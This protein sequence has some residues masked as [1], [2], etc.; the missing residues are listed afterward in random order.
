MLHFVIFHIIL[1]IV[2]QNSQDSSLSTFVANSMSVPYSSTSSSCASLSMFPLY[3]GDCVP[4]NEQQ[5]LLDDASSISSALPFQFQKGLLYFGLCFPSEKQFDFSAEHDVLPSLNRENLDARNDI[6]STALKL[7]T[8]TTKSLDCSVVSVP[9][10]YSLGKEVLPPP[11]FES[12]TSLVTSTVTL[13]STY[14]VPQLHSVAATPVS[15]AAPRSSGFSPQSPVALLL[16]T[17]A[18]SPNT[19]TWLTRANQETGTGSLLLTTANQET[20]TGSSLLNTA[21]QE[22]GT[23]LSLLTTANQELGNRSTKT[24]HKPAKSELYKTELCRAFSEKGSCGYGEKCQFAHGECDR[25]NILRH[26]KYKTKQCWTY[27]STGFCYYGAR[28]NFIHDENRLDRNQGQ[29][30]DPKF[31]TKLDP[32]SGINRDPSF[33]TNLNPASGINLVPSSNSSMNF[34]PRRAVQWDTRLNVNSDPNLEVNSDLAELSWNHRAK[35]ALNTGGVGLNFDSRIALSLK[36]GISLNSQPKAGQNAK[37]NTWNISNGTVP[38]SNGMVPVSSGMV[39]VS[40]GM[41]RSSP[42]ITTLDIGARAAL[43]SGQNLRQR[44]QFNT[45]GWNIE[46][47]NFGHSSAFTDANHAELSGSVARD[48]NIAFKYSRSEFS[49]NA[50]DDKLAHGRSHLLVLSP[51]QFPPIQTKISSTNV[52]RP[53]GHYLNKHKGLLGTSLNQSCTESCS[54]SH[55]SKESTSNIWSSL[56]K[57]PRGWTLS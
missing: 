12:L 47:Q 30:S 33:G 57:H 21:N 15:I 41:V 51:P 4:S 35:Q 52:L 8:E 42:P 54:S 34:D 20:G 48:K 45:L 28:C 3:C 56:I 55:A 32:A 16:Q 36:P 6:K 18:I 5:S 14:V 7:T 38:V 13:P 23:E 50:I 46:N 17:K 2:F 37:P 27:H 1:C 10:Q 43:S 25:R 39:P 26:A 22:K 29:N 19:G 9:E 53:N 24:N 44:N 49:G 11:G 40:N 31:A